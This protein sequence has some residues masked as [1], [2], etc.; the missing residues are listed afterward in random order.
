MYEKKR[1]LFLLQASCIIRAFAGAGPQLLLKRPRGFLLPAE[2]AQPVH[3]HSQPVRADGDQSARATRPETIQSYSWKWGGG[4]HSVCD[5]RARVSGPRNSSHC[6]RWSVGL[7]AC[8]PGRPTQSPA[9]HPAA[10]PATRPA[11]RSAPGTPFPAVPS[12]NDGR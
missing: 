10:H 9:T 4:P 7:L 11:T 12:A 1:M 3:C 5:P 8:R 2:R 6:W